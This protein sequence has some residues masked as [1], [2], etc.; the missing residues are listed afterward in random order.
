MQLS[1][2]SILRVD[3][4]SHEFF[5]ESGSGTESRVHTLD[6][7]SFEV[8]KGQ[9]VSLVGPSGC[10]KT[11][12]LNAV[13]GLQLP[14]S[15]KIS[16]AGNAP[17]A[18]RADVGYMFATDCLLPWRRTIDNVMFAMEVRGVPAEERIDR[19][20]HLLQRVGLDGFEM[21]YP[22][23]LSRGMRQRAALAR[24]FALN[25]SILLMDE[26]FGALDAQ[27]KL[28]LE[29]LLLSLWEDG[30]R[31]TVL[32]VTHDL[33]E[34]LVLSD[35]VLVFSRSP[36]RIKGDYRV[37]FVRPRDPLALQGANEYHEVFSKLW[38]DLGTELLPA[39]SGQRAG[40]ELNQEE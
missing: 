37:P 14:S 17:K 21:A 35:R 4:V 27:T 23:Q 3:G 6:N 31:T 7:V 36:G 13:A 39:S 40:H 1:T 16:L 30:E 5:L 25:S 15:G 28:I 22:S 20:R 9:F 2:P 34:A 11:T 24:T 38:A 12:L 33:H 8:P 18:G 19:A 26:P 10:G 29:Q 32:F